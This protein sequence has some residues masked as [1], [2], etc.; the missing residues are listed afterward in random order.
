[1]SLENFA[2]LAIACL[3]VN[4]S[5][6]RSVMLVSPVSGYAGRKPSFAPGFRR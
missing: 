2:L 1:M 5:A 6:G 3:T 4:L